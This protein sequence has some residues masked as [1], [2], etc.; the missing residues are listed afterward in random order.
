MLVFI[1]KVNKYSVT[2]YPTI[3]IK[4]SKTKLDIRHKTYSINKPFSAHRSNYT[5]FTSAR[6]PESVCKISN[7]Y[8][9]ADLVF[10]SMHSDA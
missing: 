4:I 9:V 2:T 3:L 1:I 5:L 7:R 6:Q 8:V 10:N